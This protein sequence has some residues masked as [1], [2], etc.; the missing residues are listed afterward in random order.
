MHKSLSKALKQRN[1]LLCSWINS[2]SPIIAEIMSRCGF[3]FLVVDTE[4]SA[5]DVPQVQMI[6]QAIKAGNPNCLPMVRLT[7]NSYSET[8]R[9]LDAGAMGVIAPFIN[10]KEEAEE[11][12]RSVKYAPE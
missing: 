8:K 3:D 12:V 9:Y 7:G 11:L 4:H 1:Y 2:A 10:S 5:V 6:F